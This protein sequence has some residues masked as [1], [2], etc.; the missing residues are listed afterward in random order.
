MQRSE[1]AWAAMRRHIRSAS[2]A[3]TDQHTFGSD[4]TQ[5]IPPAVAYKDSDATTEGPFGVRLARDS[6]GRPRLLGKGAIPFKDRCISNALMV[7]DHLLSRRLAEKYVAPH[8]G[9]HL[10]KVRRH[11]EA[12]GPGTLY[13]IDRRNNL[14]PEEFRREYLLP[15]IPV[16]LAGAA[17][18]WPCIGKWTLDYFAAHYGDDKVTITSGVPYHD[19]RIEREYVL[20]REVIENANPE[21]LKYLRFHPMLAL[22][23]ELVDDFPYGWFATQKGR[24]HLY[25]QLQFFIGTK[26]TQTGTHNSQ[27]ANLFV[28]VSGEKIWYLHPP[29]YTAFMDPM[30]SRSVYRLSRHNTGQV[31]EQPY[32]PLDGYKVH[33]RE[34]DVLWNPPFYWHS[35]ENLTDT[36]GVGYRWNDKR[37]AV[38]QSLTMFLLDWLAI[39]P[40]WYHMFKVGRDETRRMLRKGGRKSTG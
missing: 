14:S 3:R 37:L 16:V 24:R 22:H 15:G 10:A 27:M 12:N 5:R 26:G 11:L 4:R 25:T 38:S 23:P 28:M 8:R 9:K 21:D 36:I 17:K 34:G 7:A 20:M 1:A 35:V 18:D 19:P 32:W 30:T 13:P 2:F 6:V 40:T 29:A 31:F 39:N 33:L